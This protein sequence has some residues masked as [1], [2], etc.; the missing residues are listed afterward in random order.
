M[1][2]ISKDFPEYLHQSLLHLDW[3][4][5]P[6]A[7][8]PVL[9]LT[10]QMNMMLWQKGATL[11][12]SRGDP[13]L[14][15]IPDPRGFYPVQEGS[16][17]IIQVAPGTVALGYGN[18]D[19]I[20]TFT[21]NTKC[22]Y[23]KKGS[24]IRRPR[25]VVIF[26]DELVCETLGAKIQLFDEF[27]DDTAFVCDPRAILGNFAEALL[28]N[29]VDLVTVG[30]A[31]DPES[32]PDVIPTEGTS[33]ALPVDTN[34]LFG[35]NG[36]PMQHYF[37]KETAYDAPGNKYGLGKYISFTDVETFDT[38]TWAGGDT[39]LLTI[40]TQTPYG[41]L[42]D[43]AFYFDGPG[44]TAHI[45]LIL[46]ARRNFTKFTHAIHVWPLEGDEDLVD[47]TI[48]M[49]QLADN[50]LNAKNGPEFPVIFDSS[51]IIDEDTGDYEVGVCAYRALIGP[52]IMKFFGL[53][54]LQVHPC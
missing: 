3:K 27:G 45:G 11:A 36:F 8:Y 23:G 51:V 48:E 52:P 17:A 47:G 46:N 10:S 31:S 19:T 35:L 42:L 34:N 7:G 40:T 14:P 26:A 16:P 53:E 25:T 1:T 37:G 50:A 33:L 5:R 24:L 41:T 20:Y 18:I 39:Y 38:N 30:A 22:P 9:A 2:G 21:E 32:S 44:I 12:M 15:W 29:G 4:L 28:N 13:T 54:H 6:A 43:G 49:C